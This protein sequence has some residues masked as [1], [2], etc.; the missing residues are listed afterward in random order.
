MASLQ[1]DSGY[2]LEKGQQLAPVDI[3]AAV[4]PAFAQYAGQQL[5]SYG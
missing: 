1:S 3:G 2:F 5:G 4:V